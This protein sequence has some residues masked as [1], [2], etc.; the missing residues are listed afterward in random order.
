MK[1]KAVWLLAFVFLTGS[2]L[3]PYSSVQAAA[4]KPKLNIKKL[5]MT[6]G[7][8]FQ[9]RVYNLKKKQK[10]TYTSS[11]QEI[12]SIGRIASNGKRATIKARSI[13][14]ATVNATV[15][16]GKKVVRRLKCQI[17]VTPNAFSIKFPKRKIHLQTGSRFRLKPI[18]KPNTSMEQ[19]IFESDNPIVASVSCRGVVTAISP[20]KATITATLLSSGLT[21]TCTI[22][23]RSQS[24]T[25]AHDKPSKYNNIISLLN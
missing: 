23:V 7:N 15:H 6:T 11:N 1:K 3:S 10:V 18:I 19:P 13:G 12:I 22:E 21:A 2:L 9:L 5:N 16:K 25:T 24:D 14:S 17:K 4:K 8:N 20:G